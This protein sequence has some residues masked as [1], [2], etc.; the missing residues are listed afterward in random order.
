MDPAG[1]SAR[2]TYVNDECCSRHSVENHTLQRLHCRQNTSLL[3]YGL[4]CTTVTVCGPCQIE[5]CDNPY[6]RF[7][8]E[9]SEDDDE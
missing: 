9:E 6:N 2:P 1:Q 5:E 3:L 8:L 4:P 7:L